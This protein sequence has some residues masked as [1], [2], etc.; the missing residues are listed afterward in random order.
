MNLASSSVADANIRLAC[1]ACVHIIIIVVI[2]INIIIVV[3]EWK[4]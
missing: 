4:Q 1:A 2:I 3:I